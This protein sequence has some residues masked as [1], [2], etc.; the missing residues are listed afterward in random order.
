MKT[1]ALPVILMLLTVGCATAKPAK[2]VIWETPTI[3]RAHEVIGPISVSE[4]VLEG[5]GD[6]IQGLASFISRDGRVSSQ[7]PPDMKTA[8]EIKREKY[9]EMIFEKLGNKAKEYDADAVIGTEY[10][11][12]PPYA[13]FSAKATVSARGTMVKYKS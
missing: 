5:P 1:N 7:I 13:T 3:P 10:V 12:A 6:A 8:L 11:Y 4:E 9:K 2:V